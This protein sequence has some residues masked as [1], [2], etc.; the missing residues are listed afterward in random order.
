MVSDMDEL[1][2]VRQKT[3]GKWLQLKMGIQVS[4]VVNSA[5]ATF[6]EKSGPSLTLK[7]AIKLLKDEG[8]KWELVDYKPR[9]SR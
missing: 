6:F 8:E 3:T 7:R 1:C 9:T 2:R 5:S 4:W